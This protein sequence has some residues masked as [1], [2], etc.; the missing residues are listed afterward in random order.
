MAALA[1]YKAEGTLFDHA[2]RWRTRSIYSHVELVIG[3]DWYTSS[4]RDGGVRRKE[5]IPKDGRWDF[6]PVEVEI[7]R[8]I[9][10]YAR[11]QGQGYDWLGIAGH[12]IGIPRIHSA[13]RW[14]CSEWVAEALGLG[15]AW[16]WTPEGI[17]QH[18]GDFPVYTITPPAA[19][20]AALP[21][22]PT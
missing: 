6:V 10:L 12:A 9:R 21:G 1:F 2:I 15:R 22:Y 5:I 14:T 7:E 19:S 13:G 11:T 20:E 4:P 3:P 8:V 18:L 16:R 17:R